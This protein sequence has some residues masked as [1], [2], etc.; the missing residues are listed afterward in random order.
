MATFASSAE[1]EGSPRYYGWRVVLAANLGVM[2]SF[3]SLLVYTF[4]VFLKPLTIEFG[5]SREAV[6]RAFGLAAMALALFSPLLGRA[7]DRNSPRRIVLPCVVVFGVAFAS[8]SLLTPNLWH[9][10]GVFLVLGIAG[11]A[12]TQMGYSG[13]I[14]SW[15]EKRRGLAFAVV[16]A[17]AG[18]GSIVLPVAA[19][20]LIAKF[21]WRMAYLI[22]GCVVL[23]VGLPLSARYL[24]MKQHGERVE[25]EGATVREA[26]R[27]R[28]YWILVATLF[29][30]SIAVNGAI[31]HLVALL[32]DR[33]I[34]AGMAAVA[35]SALGG[36]SFVGRLMTG[37]LL[38]RF[39]G[40]RI[41]FALLSSMAAGILLLARASTIKEGILA[42]V[43][44]GFGL[45][46]EADVTPYLLARYFGLR[47]FST[48]YGLSWTFYA[49]AGALGPAILGRV[50]D[51]TGSYTS[52]L[53]TLAVPTLLSAIL[54]LWMPRYKPE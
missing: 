32:T 17:G 8:L 29:L 15:F 33:G 19:Q 24:R 48:L 38:D 3:G 40:P 2:V 1:D 12:T 11:N 41:A 28:S 23:A 30:S 6:S 10:Y 45:G 43:L 20:A 21:G 37:A 26:L 5:W 18:L 4:S 27:Q 54:M 49:L 34:T 13:A 9:L 42:A 53:S 25:H 47:A 35:A 44:I 7:L 16:M 36:A 31:T 46:G 51:L 50:F 22:L 39:F 14:A 52:V